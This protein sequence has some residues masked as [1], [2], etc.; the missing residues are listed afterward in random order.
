MINTN[1]T[2]PDGI[3][4]NKINYFISKGIDPSI[5]G[6]D[7]EMVKMKIAKEDE[8]NWTP[9]Q[10]ESAELEYKRYLHLCLKEGKGIVPNKIMDEFWH[11]HILD[12]RAYSKDT[13]RVFGHYLHHFPYFGIR[14]EEDAAN[15][16]SAFERTKGLYEA[17]FAE[18]MAREEHQD[19]WHDCENRCWH[20]CSEG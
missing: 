7:L 8:L 15:L 17:H 3:P 2:V 9:E 6:L 18:P 14:G 4:A 16:K 10:V 5:A 20:A 19:C 1:F 13:E 12:T 11:Y